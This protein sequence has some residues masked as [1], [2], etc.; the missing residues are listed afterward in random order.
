[1]PR[2]VASMKTLLKF[3]MGAAIAG[4]LVNMLMK[5]RSGNP[6]ASSDADTSASGTS[7]MSYADHVAM[8]A[9]GSGEDAI[10]DTNTVGSSDD[11]Q[12]RQ[13]QD[14]RGAQNVLDS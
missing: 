11:A 13:P 3:A 2:N 1:M 14:W 9:A 8:G 10:A 5:R 7:E 12:G 4:T 6:M